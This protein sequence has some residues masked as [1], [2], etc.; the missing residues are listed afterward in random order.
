MFTPLRDV[1]FTCFSG[2]PLTFA[3]RC[4]SSPHVGR[5]GSPGSSRSSRALWCLRRNRK[6]NWDR[7]GRCRC[8]RLFGFV[9]FHR[10]GKSARANGGGGLRVGRLPRMRWVFND[11]SQSRA[12]AQ[13]RS[14]KRLSISATINNIFSSKMFTISSNL[15]MYPTNTCNGKRVREMEVLGVGRLP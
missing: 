6:K 7:K 9:A 14:Q 8:R 1:S 15:V 10:K 11:G 2:H 4:P 3:E 5:R 12:S 13:N